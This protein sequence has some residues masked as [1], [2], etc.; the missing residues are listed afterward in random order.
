ME[1]DGLLEDRCHI[2]RM[3]VGIFIGR[4]ILE[5]LNREE[6]YFDRNIY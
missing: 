2:S 6:G 5:L 3:E 1:E 4:G